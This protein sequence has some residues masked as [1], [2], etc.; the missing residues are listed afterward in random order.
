MLIF[1]VSF[2]VEEDLPIHALE[3]VE[4]DLDHGIVSRGCQARESLPPVEVSL[5]VVVGM[6]RLFSVMV[7]LPHHFLPVLE[8]GIEIW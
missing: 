4:T 3:Q 6:D 5:L 8:G 7:Y 2:V 1:R